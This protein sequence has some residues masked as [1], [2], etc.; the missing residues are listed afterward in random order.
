MSTNNMKTQV[1]DQMVLLSQY[2]PDIYDQLIP[3]QG[4]LF[5]FYTSLQMFYV[6]AFVWCLI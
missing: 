1:D 3:E 4:L 5:I 2:Y 6:Y